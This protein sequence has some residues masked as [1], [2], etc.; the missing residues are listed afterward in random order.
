MGINKWKVIELWFF[1]AR[2]HFEQ[3]TECESVTTQYW[4]CKHGTSLIQSLAA[5]EALSCV[6][7][8]EALV[9]FPQRALHKSVNLNTPC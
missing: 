7:G 2:L 4:S 3:L 5:A 1:R 6:A 8:Q 9:A